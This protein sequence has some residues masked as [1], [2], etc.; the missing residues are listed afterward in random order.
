MDIKDQIKRS[1][2]IV[3]V[4][5]LYVNL[6]PAGKYFKALCPFHTEKTPSFFVMP[7]K[8]TYSCYGCNRFGDIFTLVQE[9]E[10]ISFPEAMNLLIER[11]NIPVQKPD[12][13]KIIKKDEYI[14]INEI[15][16]E[17]FRK[18]LNGSTGDKKAIEYLSNRGIHANTMHLFSLGYAENKWDALYLYLDEKKCD[19]EKA[20]QLGLLIK[21][22]NKRI[23]DR[24]RGRIIFPIFSESG[25]VI[26]FGGRTLFN[27]SNKYLNSPDT[28]LF[29]KGKHLYGFHLAK[30]SIRETKV[31]ILVE[32]YFDMIS[33]YQNGIENAIASL[34]TALTETQIN[35]IK[36]FS[37]EIYMF[38]DM[39]TAGV[40]ATLRGIEKMFQQNINPRIMSTRSA[41]DPDDFIRDK[42]KKAF[43]E[44]I[45]SAMPGFKFILDKISR[46]YSLNVPEKK[47]NA[48]EKVRYFLNQIE[49]P[50]IRE[51]YKQLAAD[52]LKVEP[53]MINLDRASEKRDDAANRPLLIKTD[54][55]E[56]IESILLEPEFIKEI[57]AL[58]T[59]EI[60]SVL[61]SKNI[62]MAIF[63]NFDEETNQINYQKIASEI[64]ESEKAR[65]NRIFLSSES[66]KKDRQ[67]IAENIEASFLSFQN[68]LNERK[69]IEL[70]QEIRIAERDGDF[71]KVNQLMVLKNQFVRKR[72]KFSGGK[73]VETRQA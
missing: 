60:L 26:A 4:A 53:K 36:R 31:A 7:E 10:N 3:D 40:S 67:K 19:I 34:G 69:T 52:F 28:P 30:K 68:T 24:F 38:Y 55:K 27:E 35:L 58:F 61:S 59:E 63:N 50:M 49:D 32:G 11:F 33:L 71:N 20:I 5:S 6:K 62:I 54:E 12:Y 64:N 51:G 57:K 29:K 43:K 18:N 8:N 14:K 66:L 70:N 73:T 15:A 72:H 39:D 47:R 65:F 9:M 56:F 13:K 37:D 41:K 23:Y 48:L 22:D 46:D 21:S 25:S 16:N 42:G 1:A 44:L 45:D 17:F 2:S